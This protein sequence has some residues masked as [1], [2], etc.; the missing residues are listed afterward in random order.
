M[1]LETTHKLYKEHTGKKFDLEHWCEMLKDHPKRSVICDPSKSGSRSSKRY[2]PDTEEA[3]KEGPGGSERLEERKAATRRLKKKANKTVIDLV[4]TQLQDLSSN[5]S[6]MSEIF[7]DFIA[8]A[9]EEKT[10]KMMMREEKLRAHED[11]I[12]MMGTSM[13]TPEQAAYYEQTKV[14]IMKRRSRQSSSSQ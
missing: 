3:G 2:N 12:M 1:I 14:D 13:M 6:G 8:V 5:S 9:K 10:Q 11:R 4:T 7:K